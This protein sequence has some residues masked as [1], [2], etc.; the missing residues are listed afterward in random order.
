VSGA[1]STNSAIAVGYYNIGYAGP[2]Y[3]G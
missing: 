1:Y 3:H 2:P